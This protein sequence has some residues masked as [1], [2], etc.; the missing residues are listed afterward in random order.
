MLYIQQVAV[1]ELSF[2]R[3]LDERAAADSN[4]T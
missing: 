3:R 2:A 1:S 4:S